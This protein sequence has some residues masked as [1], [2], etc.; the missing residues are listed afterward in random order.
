[1]ANMKIA[2]HPFTLNSDDPLKTIPVGE[3]VAPF[4]AAG[5]TTCSA[6]ATPVLL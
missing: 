6:R 3:P 2:G 5:T 4:F 1:V